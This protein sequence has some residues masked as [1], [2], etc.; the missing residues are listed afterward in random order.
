MKKASKVYGITLILCVGVL[1]I[2]NQYTPILL[3]NATYG[4]PAL[5]EKGYVDNLYIGS[6]MFRQGL[7]IQTLNQNGEENYILAYNGNQPTLEYLQLKHL[8]DNGVE[9]KNLYVDM[10]VYSAWEEPEIS[11]EKIFMEVDLKKK[12]ELWQLIADKESTS[13]TDAWRIFVNSNNEV[14]LTWF[15]IYPI[16]NT[17]F[18]SGGT[19][20]ETAGSS[21]DTLTQMGVFGA[22]GEMNHMQKEAIQNITDLCKEYEINIMF[23]ETPKFETIIENESYINVIQKY[24]SVL[25]ENEVSYVLL[26]ETSNNV[27]L[28]GDDRSYTFDIKNADYF[29]DTIHLSSEGRVEFSEKIKSERSYSGY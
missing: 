12:W 13:W 29:M 10:Y 8:L 1:F 27:L 21:Y 28:D 22:E 19:L 16:L 14:L 18:L 25:Q 3:K 5:I 26:E 6:S 24:C 9:I 11:D 20:L 4:M 2:K 7:D 23:I 17:Q 15:I